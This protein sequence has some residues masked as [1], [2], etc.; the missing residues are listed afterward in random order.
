MDGGKESLLE[1]LVAGGNAAKLFE[2]VEKPLDPIALAIQDRIVVQFLAARAEGRNDGGDAV[3]RQTLAN[4]V[5]IVAFVERCRFQDVVRVEA[6]VE[7]FKL[8][9][10]V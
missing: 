9:A 3:E 8:P 10:I 1:F 7:A 2:L 6:V 5:G 4:A